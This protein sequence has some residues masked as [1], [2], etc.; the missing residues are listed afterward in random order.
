MI[1]L[2]N[3]KLTFLSS[4]ILS[5][6]ITGCLA[7]DPNLEPLTEV[8]EEEQ[9][10]YRE[11]KTTAPASID[12]MILANRTFHEAPMLTAKVKAGEL[13][14]VNERLPDN[15]LVV[16]P[17]EE[18]GTYG[19][20]IRRALTGDVIQTQGPVKAFNDNLMGYERP[21]PPKSIQLNLAESFDLS[22]DGKTAIAKIRK[23]VKWSDGVPFTVDDILF[24]YYDMEF[25]DD[26]RHAPY[27]P[28]TGEL[29]ANRS[30]LKKSMTTR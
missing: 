19:G 25:N 7:P 1:K 20:T 28:L 11:V 22:D 12:P 27:R 4:I 16:V 14:P 23:G 5:I 30:N 18:I 6:I 9:S 8:E 2:D 24:W 21:Y 10:S 15:P 26:V 29:M 17:L 13:P 3:K